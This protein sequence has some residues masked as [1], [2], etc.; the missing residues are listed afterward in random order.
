MSSTDLD[1]AIVGGG[2]AGLRIAQQLKASGARIR[3][4]ERESEVGG[5]TTSKVVDGVH[6]NTGAVFVYRGTNT[7]K[8]CAE[9]GITYETVEPR[10]FGIHVN[11][12][13]LFATRAEELADALPLSPEGKQDIRG[14]VAKLSETYDT[15]G[16][17]LEGADH[18]A[19][20]SLSEF[21]GPISEDAWSFVYA[22][23]AG[24]CVAS[25]DELAAKFGL[26]YL[27]SFLVRDGASRGYVPEGMQSIFEALHRQVADLV[28]LDTTVEEV[29]PRP[30]GSWE[31]R[32]CQGGVTSTVTAQRVVLA[33]PGPL[34]PRLVPGL[35]DWKRTAIDAIPTP[36]QMILTAVV[37]C[38][39]RP[40]W[41]DF[42]YVVSMG[43]RFHGITQPRTGDH[44]A[45]A[46]GHRTYFDMFRGRDTLEELHAQDDDTVIDEWLE[47][48][49]R[50]LPD[51]RG[52]VTGTYLQRWDMAF[53]S[54]SHDRGEHLADARR[55]VG[56]MHFAGD[57]TS[58][59]AG[60]HGALGE[61][62]RVVS[63]LRAE[64]GP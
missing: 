61:A 49:Y 25:P 18:L 29:A 24:A 1:L 57:Y 59:T 30:E 12:E 3:V 28:S 36:A 23:V 21:I 35:P 38:T 31:L 60:S 44:Y 9:L 48:F 32:I 63:D 52:R 33:V 10:T 11:G 8:L 45:A 40:Q 4:F 39:D 58:E 16:L 62:D 22:A 2:P 19:T 26:R 47:D 17:S 37:D 41:A 13:T 5:R 42:F 34:V 50:V 46:G 20:V 54:P 55:P 51:A 6:V 64:L 43:T 27:A 53:A 56:T 15:Y 7:D 14:L